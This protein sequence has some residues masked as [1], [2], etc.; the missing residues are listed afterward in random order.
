MVRP[1][2]VKG[3]ATVCGAA[4]IPSAGIGSYAA[5][6]SAN[7]RLTTAA[8]LAGSSPPRS[9]VTPSSSPRAM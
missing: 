7:A 1:V 6:P 2:D 8:R 5:T 9:I 4:S 3:R